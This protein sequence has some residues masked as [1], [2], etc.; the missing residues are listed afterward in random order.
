[1]KLTDEQIVKLIADAFRV[2]R[3]EGME[4]GS[5][6]GYENGLRDG[7][8]EGYTEGYD[9]GWDKGYDAAEKDAEDTRAEEDEY[10]CKCSQCTSP[11][12]Y[13]MGWSDG[14]VGSDVDPDMKENEAY[15]DG[16]LQGRDDRETKVELE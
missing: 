3:N 6:D 4:V 5:R 1:M 13:D 16:Y 12:E 11:K 10:A 9:A 8:D 15:M 14:Y 2:G 7:H